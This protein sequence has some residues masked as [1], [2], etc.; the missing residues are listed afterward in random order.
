M[1]AEELNKAGFATVAAVRRLDKIASLKP[2][3]ICTA[4]LDVAEE[5]SIDRCL[6][7]VRASVGE[8]DVLVNCAGV[9]P[10]VP[11]EFVPRETGRHTFE[12]NLFGLIAR[13]KKCL[14]HIR[15]QRRGR[16]INVSRLRQL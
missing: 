15:G 2:L 3:G 13:A 10:M 7:E 6:A 9:L 14:P 12:V 11:A 1:I 4:A 5:D 16:V 8:V